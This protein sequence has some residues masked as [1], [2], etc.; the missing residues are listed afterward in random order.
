MIVFLFPGL[1]GLH[2]PFLPQQVTLLNLLSIGLPAFA[3][4][5]NRRQ[6]SGGSKNTFFY[7]VGWFA[8][9]TGTLFGIAGLIILWLSVHPWQETLE[10][11]RTLLLSALIMLGLTG[12]IRASTDGESAP[13]MPLRIYYLLA[14]VCVSLY[15]GAMYLPPTANFFQLTALSLRQWMRVIGVVVITN[16]VCKVTDRLNIKLWQRVLGSSQNAIKVN[17]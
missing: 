13:R 16:V 12:V 11:Q 10:T 4:A 1:L 6:A 3:V 5:L 15:F 17:C 9:R 14:L 2:Y 7:E 8:L